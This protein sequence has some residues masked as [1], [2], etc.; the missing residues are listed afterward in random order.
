MEII[1]HILQ[2]DQ[3]GKCESDPTSPN[4]T[5][6]NSIGFH[7]MHTESNREHRTHRLGKKAITSDYVKGRSIYFQGTLNKGRYILIPTTFDSN[8]E[9]EYFLRVY[10][11]E[12][13]VLK[14]LTLDY[15]EPWSLFSCCCPGPMC[16]SILN[17]HGASGLERGICNLQSI[18]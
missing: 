3:R 8:I 7:I 11:E 4:R 6:Y 14:P 5:V 16:V 2:S 13:T 17:V 1:V 9:T 15:P 18:I 10:T 12:T